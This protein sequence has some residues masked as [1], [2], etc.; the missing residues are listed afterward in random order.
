LP[1]TV[2]LLL[3]PNVQ[4]RGEVR[5]IAPQ[6]DAATRMQ[7]VRIALD[8]PP[9]SFR[10][11]ATVTARLGN[12]LPSAL[13]VPAA[14]V[15]S[16]DGEDFV[17]VVDLPAGTVSMRKVQLTQDGGNMRVVAGLAPG[18]RVVTAGIHSLTPGQLVHIE[19]DVTP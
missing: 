13:R 9:P 16:R 18:T 5:E 6:A 17:W 15:L 11:G 12:D 1:F 7:R 10:L 3:Q 19:Q 2:S 8:D 4:I 14:A